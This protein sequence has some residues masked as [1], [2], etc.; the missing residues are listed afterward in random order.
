MRAHNPAKEWMG[1]KGI[2]LQGEEMLV[3]VMLET[4]CKEEK[5][6]AEEG[7]QGRR[8]CDPEMEKCH[9]L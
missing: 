4:R 5:R 2:F 6:E 1:R 9:L 7:A 3:A 8:V